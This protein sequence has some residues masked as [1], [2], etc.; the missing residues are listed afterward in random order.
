MAH[1]YAN[2]APTQ[3][4]R[5]P[6]HRRDDAWIAAFLRRAAIGHLGQARDGQP[7]VTPTNFWFD[8]AARLIYFHSNLAGRM[9]DT[10]ENAPQVCL[11]VSEM[12]Q[13][14]ASNLALEF[15]VQYRS[16]MVFGRVILLSGQEEKRRALSGLLEKYFPH[17]R[18]GVEYRPIT[19]Q[20]LART[21][22]YA[23]EIESWSGK[24][25]WPEQA[26]QS[27]DWPPRP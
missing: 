26:Q 2:A 24:E 22:V 5:L 21:S 15:S 23:L 17:S 9:R 27:A 7:F 1:K 11:E 14:L 8:E 3:F 13:F 10:L 18:A 19:D 4:Q 16:V 6:E 25:N 12:G 20:E